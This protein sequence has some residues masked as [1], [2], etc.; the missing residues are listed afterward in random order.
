MNTEEEYIQQRRSKLQ[1]LRDL[2]IDVYPRRFDFSHSIT[3]IV[4][5]LQDVPGEE[6][7]SLHR[8]ESVAGRIVAHRGFGK[9]AFVNLQQDGARLQVYLRKDLLGD[10]FA[11]FDCLDLGD[12]IGAEGE[13]FRTK[14]GELTVK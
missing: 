10:Q 9:A 4:D 13:L 7:E 8:R 11:I 2:G 14:T 6:L 3:E 5:E 1:K 12:F